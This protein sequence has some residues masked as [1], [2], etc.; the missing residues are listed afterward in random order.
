MRLRRNGPGGRRHAALAGPVALFAT[1]ALAGAGAC[2]DDND[3][4]DDSVAAYVG[5]VEITEAELDGVADGLRRDLG[6]EIEG[7]L[8]RLAQDGDMDEDSLAEHEQRRRGELEDQVAVNRTRTLE[9]RILT[10]A[11]TRH[12]EETGLALDSPRVEHH[13]YELGLPED[14]EYVQVVAEFFAVL[15]TLQAAVEAVPP[16]EADQREVYDVLVDEGLTTASFEQAQE[17]LTQ[18]LMG[19]QVAMRNLLDQLVD[20]A[21]VRVH[22]DYDLVYRVPV[23]VGSGEAWLAVPLGGER[24]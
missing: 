11:A 10:E 3:W 8:E 15:G 17:V 14:S 18:D 22:P 9:M 4:E 19:R 21:Q 16:T 1:L 20:D 13:A 12:A 23:P 2:T 7:E 5:E 6:A 24:V